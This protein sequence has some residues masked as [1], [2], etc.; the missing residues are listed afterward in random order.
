M[1][2][3]GRKGCCSPTINLKTHLRFSNHGLIEGPLSHDMS[4]HVTDEVFN[5]ASHL[6]GGMVSTLGTA[7]LITGASAHGNPWA[8]VA[9]SLYGASLMLLFYASFAHHAIWGSP[10]L[11]KA[12]RLLDY[13]SIY[14]LIPGT[15]TPF[16]FVCMHNQWE[17]WVFF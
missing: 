6:M 3:N 2:N 12:L 17:G 10:D 15:M 9:F 5:A 8:I 13:V 14:F 1:L 4:P 7:V 11:M 16:C